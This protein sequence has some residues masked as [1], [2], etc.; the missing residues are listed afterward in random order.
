MSPTQLPQ[1]FNFYKI[2]LANDALHYGYWPIDTP[3]LSLEQA[4]EA[5]TE[6]LYNQFPPAPAR[7]LDVGCG[8]GA[9]GAWLVNQGYEVV[10]L[11]P[12][13]EL[14]AYAN[15]HNPGP[16]YLACGFLDERD[17]LQPPEQYDVIMLQESLQ[18]FPDIQAVFS[19]IKSLLR[20]QN[21]RVIICDEV[22]YNKQTQAHS[23]VKD[24]VAIEQTFAA[25][26][27]YSIYH[28]EIGQQVWQTCT[29]ILRRFTEQKTELLAASGEIQPGLEHFIQ[30]WT[31]QLN[32]Y[33]SEHIGYEVWGL[34]CDDISVRSYQNGDERRI[35][36]AFNQ[37]FGV[38]RQVAHWYWKFR[39]NPVGNT[40]ISTAWQGETLAA[41][42]SGYPLYLSLNK[43]DTRLVQ[44]IGDTFSMPAFRKVGHGTS[45]LLRRVFRHFERSH[46]ERQVYFAYGFNTHKI[47]RLGQ[48]FLGYVADT[49]VYNWQLNS[50]RLDLYRR[51]KLRM[52]RL[53]GYTVSRETQV[54]TWADTLWQR[55]RSDYPWLIQRDQQYLRWRYELNPDFEYEFY[56]VKRWGYIVGVWLVRKHEHSLWLGDALFC[57]KSA[58]TA[59]AVGLTT[60]LQQHPDVSSIEGWFAEKPTW[61]VGMLQQAGFAPVRQHENL[62]LCLLT[63]YTDH[64]TPTQIAENFY[65]TW[66]DSDLF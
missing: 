12:S 47:R 18:Y 24:T 22:S 15:A 29:E 62:Y 57:R 48:L 35:L 33:Q 51:A 50:E 55:I 10:A 52:V 16:T 19:K 1:P 54:G 58:P 21:S 39:D 7:V 38:Q 56:L 14:I 17:L 41:H 27:F 11:A 61:W 13:E 63:P 23:D 46:L 31:Y 5:L 59:M 25:L 4:Q 37:A 26:G 43:Q 6:L 8:L 32:A 45:N 28:Q 40:C 36:E 66:G 53:R 65:F 2:V 9:T 34:R 20:N 3:N 42:Y 30:G 49:P 44:H 64:V 60:M